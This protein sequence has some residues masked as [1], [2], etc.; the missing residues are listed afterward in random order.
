[1]SEEKNEN[2]SMIHRENPPVFPL[3]FRFGS[4]TDICIIDFLDVPEEHIRKV[5]YSIAITKS[6]A[7]DLIDNLEKFIS[8]E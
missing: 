4:S 6:H 3:G 8:E 7:R 5:S 2:A 1:M